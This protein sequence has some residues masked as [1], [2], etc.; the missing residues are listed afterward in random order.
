MTSIPGRF[1]LNPN[2]IKNRLKQGFASANTGGGSNAL[3]YPGRIVPATITE[4]VSGRNPP[5]TTNQRASANSQIDFDI[6][7]LAIGEPIPVIFCRRV[8]GIG[9]VMARPKVSFAAFSN[10]STTLTT[11]YHC[12][13][14]DGKIG[15]IAVKYVRRGG[16]REN[17][18]F[19][20]NYNQRAGDWL[21]GNTTT[22]QTGYDLPTLP[23]ACGGGG[24]Y[25][26]LSTIEFRH[27]TTDIQGWRRGYNVFI[28]NGLEVIRILDNTY[29]S[30][31]NIVD[32]VLWA[33]EQTRKI[34]SFL[35]DNPSLLLA[36]KFI[37]VNGLFCN[38]EFNQSD[39]LLNFLANILQ[40]FLLRLTKINGKFSLRPLL[41]V[42]RDGSINTDSIRPDFCFDERTIVPGS[43]TET[44]SDASTSIPPIL[45]MMWKQQASEDHFPLVR[46]TLVG[47][48]SQAIG[49]LE[50]PPEQHD[51]SEFCTSENHMAKVG[52]YLWNKRVLCNKTATVRLV[53]GSHSGRII[54]GDIVQIKRQIQLSN[55][56]NFLDNN[57]WEVV[58]ISEDET[59]TL[60]L[61]PVDSRW[62]SL[63]ALAV[64]A[65]PVSGQI[66]AP[67]E[68]PSCDIPGAAGDTSVPAPI[69]PTSPPDPSGGVPG[70]G[71][72]P[73]PGL[74][75]VPL[76]PTPP[77]DGAPPAGE[78][79]GPSTPGVP[80]TPPQTPPNPPPGVDVCE[81]GYLFIMAEVNAADFSGGGA[82]GPVKYNVQS[83]SGIQIEGVVLNEQE[84]NWL[85]RLH[86]QGLDGLPQS[87]VVTASEDGTGGPNSGDR[88]YPVWISYETFTCKSGA[89]P[90]PVKTYIVMKGDT[91]WDIAQR[92]YG[93][94]AL[95]PTIYNA[96]RQTI[97]NNPDLI[98]P[99]MPLK[100]P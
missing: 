81:D 8:N 74:P 51:L 50:I 22:V 42:N 26:R 77:G 37:Q 44:W 72:P 46:S 98:L 1:N 13:L 93:N 41:P 65:A 83:K 52:A 70:P 12:I 3:T 2:P 33:R 88:I 32:L 84:Y 90:P 57:V 16:C 36:A 40:Y 29:G 10:D 25:T 91:L 21:P 64:A 94:G 80:P 27:T 87:A 79:T 38:G 66:L 69:F 31:N 62:R 97:G 96:N 15:P 82:W 78:P 17:F 71:S 28:M 92:V 11:K 9:G 23:T 99:G 4:I 39:S 47:T 85:Y 59:L 86:W 45:S 7:P 63:L 76:P 56:D 55:G 18:Q 68:L 61:F 34:P 30:S 67:P 60:S 5:P 53:P 73:G 58:S 20:Q 49:N 54:E 24:L 43:Y 100:I 48:R 35:N 75:G 19:S 95:W 14:S 89:T 6:E